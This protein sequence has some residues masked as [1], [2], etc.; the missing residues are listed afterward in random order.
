MSKELNAGECAETTSLYRHFAADGEL[1][2]VGISLSAISRLGQHAEHAHWFNRIARVEI[3]QYPTRRAAMQAEK[4]A[5]L[6]EQPTFNIKRPKDAVNDKAVAAEVKR[7]IR[8]SMEQSIDDLDRKVAATRPLYTIE[9]VA[10]ELGLPQTIVMRL[11]DSGR[12]GCVDLPTIK[13]GKTRRYVTGWQLLDFFD[14]E[15][16]KSEGQAAA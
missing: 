1:L 15:H 6:G 2:Y 5:I 11:I 7:L 9:K 3:E 14:S 10:E 13:E 16:R 12:L 8:M 4:E